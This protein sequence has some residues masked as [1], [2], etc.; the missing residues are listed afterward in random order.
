MVEACWSHHG[1]TVFWLWTPLLD[2]EAGRQLGEGNLGSGWI[3]SFRGLRG[4]VCG[5]FPLYRSRFS[6][7]PEPVVK[8]EAVSEAWGQPHTGHRDLFLCVYRVSS[9]TSQAGPKFTLQLK[10]TMDLWSSCL[11]PPRAGIIYVCHCAVLMWAMD[12]TQS[13][14]ST[15]PTKRLP[16]LSRNCRQ[17]GK[18][19]TFDLHWHLCASHFQTSFLCLL[20]LTMDL[21]LKQNLPNLFS[22]NPWSYQKY[23]KKYNLLWKIQKRQL[24]VIPLSDNWVRMVLL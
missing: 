15:L 2:L 19:A 14:A 17:R 10:P 21:F 12:W 23:D 3:R 16:P 13:R 8:W 1:P 7:S 20:F 6:W 18:D 24:F 5:P 4:A 9:H 11:H 22:S